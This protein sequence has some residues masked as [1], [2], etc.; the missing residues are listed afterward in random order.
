MEGHLRK[1]IVFLIISLFLTLGFVL[2]SAKLAV[3][4]FA[5]EDLSQ[6]CQKYLTAEDDVCKGMTQTECQKALN[7]CLDYYEEQSDFYEGKVSEKQAEKKTLQNEIYVLRNKISKLDN[8]I[9]KSNL[10]IKDLSIQIDDTENSIGD[11]EQKIVEAKIRLAELLRLIEEQDRIS[12]LEIM[13]AEEQLSD[14]FDEM[15]ALEALSLKNQELLADIKELKGHLEVEKDNLAGEKQDYEYTIAASEIQKQRSQSLKSDQEWLLERTKGQEE[16]YQ[17]YLQETEEKATEIRKKIFQLA[18]VTEEE[19]PSYE[20]AYQLAKYVEGVT[21]VRAAL[22]LG[23]LQV[24]SAIGKNVGQCNCQGRSYCAHPEIGWED[25]MRSNQY[26]AFKEI[27]EELGLEIDSTP[28]SCSVSGGKVQ[29]GGAMGPA[30]FIPTTWQIYKPKIEAIT[31]ELANPWRV[32]DAFLA[33][34]LYLK[35]FGAAS[36]ILQKEIGAV[37][38]YLCG[39]SYMTSRCQQA[40]GYWYRSSVMENASQWE[41]WIEEGVFNGK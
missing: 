7:K 26:D 29:W 37:T 5:E 30:Q 34:G 28:V 11:K 32:R 25:V 17:E 39:T 2:F 15:A 9:Y 24:E 3:F 23:L 10:M 33:A 6:E 22:I 27:V 35:D 13:L 19:A 21:G 40:G 31:G 41:D 8:E 1:A 14:F 20:E 4:V 16:L 12:L 36:Q 18:Q 38:A